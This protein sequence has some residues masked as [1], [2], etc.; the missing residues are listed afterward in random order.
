[1]GQGNEGAVDLNNTG[2]RRLGEWVV[3]LINIC[4]VSDCARF[5]RGSVCDSHREK[6]AEIKAHMIRSYDSL[7][8]L[9]M[10]TFPLRR[11]EVNSPALA[12]YCFLFIRNGSYGRY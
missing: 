4:T 3:H 6:P 5:V 11:A 8:S 7:D 1:M 12:L 9:P 10:F 2:I